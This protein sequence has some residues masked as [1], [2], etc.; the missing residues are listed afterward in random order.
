M[1]VNQGDEGIST[2]DELHLYSA[3]TPLGPWIPHARNPVVSDVRRAR[4]AGRLFRWQ[5][6]LYR[7]SQDCAERYGH[8]IVVNEVL[9]VSSLAYEEKPVCTLDPASM[10]GANRIHT[11]NT[12]EWLSV[13]DCHR[14]QWWPG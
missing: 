3:H 8:A 9:E 14:D 1:F 5:G 12:I 10:P 7:P 13:I 4:P 2:Y 6:V 11:L